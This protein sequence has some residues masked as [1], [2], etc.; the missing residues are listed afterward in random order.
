MNGYEILNQSINQSIKSAFVS[1]YTPPHTAINQSSA[2]QRVRTYVRTYSPPSTV[3]FGPAVVSRRRS[4]RTYVGV[5]PRATLL[6]ETR[7]FWSTFLLTNHDSSS[8]GPISPGTER[9]RR[10]CFVSPGGEN[11]MK[12]P[13]H[14]TETKPR[15]RREGSIDRSVHRVQ[16][17][18]SGPIII[19]VFR[20]VFPSFISQCVVCF[21]TPHHTTRREFEFEEEIYASFVRFLNCNSSI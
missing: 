14:E 20:V 4:R 8:M 13:K 12:Q 15:R 7:D 3:P 17:D 6:R 1:A 18:R 16:F 11:N 5:C 9:T 10:V 19:S 2:S 21:P